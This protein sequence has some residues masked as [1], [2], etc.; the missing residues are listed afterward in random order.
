MNLQSMRIFVASMSTGLLLSAL[1]IAPSVA[2]IPISC[3]KPIEAANGTHGPVLC[4][5]GAPNKQM[6]SWLKKSTPHVMALNAS[7]TN[8]QIRKAACADVTLMNATG[9]LVNDAYTYQFARYDWRGKRIKPA[10]F[11]LRLGV[12]FNCSN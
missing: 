7:A 4:P 2:V 8:A 11:D 6:R 5:N 12:E 3:G 1:F 10:V 9:P